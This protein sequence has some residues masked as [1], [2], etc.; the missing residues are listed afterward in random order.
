MASREENPLM[1]SD[2]FKSLIKQPRGRPK[3]ALAFTAR[4]AAKTVSSAGVLADAVS[5][6]WALDWQLEIRQ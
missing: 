6:R 3:V 2:W 5:S 4:S 1:F